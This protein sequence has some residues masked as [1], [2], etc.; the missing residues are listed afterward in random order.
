[1]IVTMTGNLTCDCG[2][3]ETVLRTATVRVNKNS[4]REKGT[5]IMFVSPTCSGCGVDR[6]AWP[7]PERWRLVEADAKRVAAARARRWPS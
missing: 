3:V 6:A 2:H 4:L 5:A 1:M 7:F